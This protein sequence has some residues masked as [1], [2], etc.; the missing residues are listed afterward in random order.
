MC[1]L[2]DPPIIFAAVAMPIARF[3][4]PT[5]LML[6]G[7]SHPGVAGLRGGDR[8]DVGTRRLLTGR[9]LIRQKGSSTELLHSFAPSLISR[10]TLHRYLT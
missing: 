3:D 6:S 8:G 1:L 4:Q 10:K 7:A 9:A 2:A 5:H